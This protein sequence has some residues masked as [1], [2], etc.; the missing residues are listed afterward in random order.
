MVRVVLLVVVVFLGDVY[1][2]I[3]LVVV[4]DVGVVCVDGRGCFGVIC[5]GNGA[6]IGGVDVFV[7]FVLLLVVFLVLVFLYCY[8]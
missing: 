5:V 1:V 2:H 7:E 6:V 4:F 8:W 3:L